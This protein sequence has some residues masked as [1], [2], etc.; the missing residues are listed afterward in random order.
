MNDLIV[1]TLFSLSSG[2]SELETK[3]LFSKYFGWATE[4]RAYIAGT[5][6]YSPQRAIRADLLRGRVRNMPH[7][8]KRM[9]II[10]ASLRDLLVMR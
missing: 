2:K 10:L 7:L 1:R 6:F 3:T 9:P 4:R 8:K 5:V